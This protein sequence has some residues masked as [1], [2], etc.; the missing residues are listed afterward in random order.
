MEKRGHFLRRKLSRNGR[1][2]FHSW[3]CDKRV[4]LYPFENL[5]ENRKRTARK[6]DKPENAGLY[7]RVKLF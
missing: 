7:E 1:V 4:N 5:D 6:I 2:P 3:S